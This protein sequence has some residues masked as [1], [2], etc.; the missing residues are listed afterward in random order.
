MHGDS[1]P[2][3][4]DWFR[5]VYDLAEGD[6]A[7][8]PWADLAPHPLLADWLRDR[9]LTGRALDI[10]CG[11]GDNAE[12]IAKAGAQT[13]AFDLSENAIAWARKR[14]PQSSVDYR[15]ADL[16]AT[17]RD[18]RGAFDFAHECYTLQALG[19]AALPAAARAI[20]QTLKP[21]AQLL[22][23]ARARDEREE[24]PGPPWPLT[25]S[26]IDTIAQA[27]LRLEALEDIPEGGPRGRHWRALFRA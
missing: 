14:F 20:A 26:Q 17:P 12:A 18:W 21:G 15:A 5:A 8:V 9:R 22:V 16:F 2:Y 6:A 24:I 1:D 23:I 3:R 11:L 19:P 4:R 10:G 27:G 7:R 13:S 25:R